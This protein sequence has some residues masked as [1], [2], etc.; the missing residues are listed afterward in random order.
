MLKRDLILV[1][2][3]EL[4]KVIAQLI[5]QRDHGAS[6]TTDVLMETIYDSLRVDKKFLLSHT[7]GEI[8]AA[9]EGEDKAGIQRM[10]IAAKTLIEESY[11]NNDNDKD[12]LYKAQEILLYVQQHD[13][14]FSIERM[15]LLDEI[16][17]KLL[18]S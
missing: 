1:Q 5:D 13:L 14:T 12:T 4:G 3:E 18:K 10:E 2:I 8:H 15:N 11:I 7:P 9:L 17:S 6:R 16:Q